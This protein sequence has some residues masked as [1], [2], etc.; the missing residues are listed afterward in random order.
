MISRNEFG[1]IREKLG[2]NLGNFPNFGKF[3]KI[4]EKKCN[5][6]QA[7]PRRRRASGEGGRDV[8]VVMVTAEAERPCKAVGT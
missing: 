8:M 7:W 4:S 1:Q 6:P 3:P 2:N 5:L